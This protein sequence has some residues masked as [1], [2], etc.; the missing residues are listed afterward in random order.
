M[1]EY[2]ASCIITNKG[3]NVRSRSQTSQRSPHGTIQETSQEL[4]KKEIDQL[5]ELYLY[6]YNIN[7]SL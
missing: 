5:H 2:N 3:N 6:K 7:I 4:C 1:C